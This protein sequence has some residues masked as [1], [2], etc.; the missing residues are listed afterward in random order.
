MGV[1]RKIT[2]VSTLGAVNMHSKRERRLAVE[3][4]RAKG[5]L[6]AQKEAVKLERARFK[7][8]R[9]DAARSAPVSTPADRLAALD[10]LHSQGHINAAELA[11]RRAVI[12][13]S[14]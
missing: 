10:V 6:D 5:D 4:G 11:D 13:G 12:L 2:A 8:E 1:L 9:H 14:I 3:E 7:A